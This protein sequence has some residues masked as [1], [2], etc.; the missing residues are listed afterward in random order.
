M[1]TA[2]IKFGGHV[3]KTNLIPKPY[4]QLP[5]K[6][7]LDDKF[8]SFEEGFFFV[9]WRHSPHL[10]AVAV[11]NQALNQDIVQHQKLEQQHKETLL[12]EEAVA[13]QRKRQFQEAE[14]ARD[15]KIK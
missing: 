9:A 15:L 11:T 1:F 6:I 5:E 12:T 8:G 4:R 14:A 13:Q 2:R 3:Q 10:E 7:S